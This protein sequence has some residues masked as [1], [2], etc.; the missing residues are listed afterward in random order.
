M[1]ES[2]GIPSSGNMFGNTNS[3]GSGL[4]RNTMPCRYPLSVKIWANRSAGVLE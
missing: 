1:G 4:F 2:A 3:V